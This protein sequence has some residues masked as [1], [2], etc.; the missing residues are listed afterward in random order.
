VVAGSTAICWA[1]VHALRVDPQLCYVHRPA[2]LSGYGHVVT[3]RPYPRIRRGRTA[4]SRAIVLSDQ[5]GSESGCSASY[6][7]D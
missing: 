1:P 5:P 6:A 7:R 2:M 4:G 3:T